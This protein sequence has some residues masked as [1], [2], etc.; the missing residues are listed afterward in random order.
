M[1]KSKVEQARELLA[2][3]GVAKEET[4]TQSSGV[5]RFPIF[6]QNEQPQKTKVQIAQEM[7]NNGMTPDQIRQNTE[8]GRVIPK[9]DGFFKTVAKEIVTPVARLGAN[10]ALAGRTAQGLVNP[11]AMQEAE[12]I[13]TNGINLPLV[14]QVKPVGVAGAGNGLGGFAR[15]VADA[16]GVGTE[17]ASTVIP[18]GKAP[19]IFGKF[20]TG[21]IATGIGTGA[22]VGGVGGGLFG[23]GRGV[24]EE[25]QRADGGF[26]LGN[27]ATDTA[28]G[29]AAGLVGGG[30][31]G[32]VGGVF[33]KVTAA[34]R[35]AR[36]PKPELQSELRSFVEG[37]RSLVNATE[38]MKRDRNT[39]VV[40]IIS[41]PT[42]FEGIK[43]V[44]GSLNVDA[45]IAT[46][47]STTD[48]LMDAN[49]SMLPRINEY[50]TPVKREDL[51]A[52]AYAKLR[53]TK[54][55]IANDKKKIDAELNAYDEYMSLLEVDELRA[56]S[57]ESA[58]IK[59]DDKNIFDA[60]ME[61][62][63]DTVFEKSEQV[64]NRISTDES[65]KV[66]GSLRTMIKDNL[67]A[68]E[69]LDKTLRGQK[70]PGGR[71]GAM[72]AQGVGAIIGSNGGPLTA[73]IG[74]KAGDAIARI[75]MN[76]RLGGSIRMG[77]IRKL[78]DD[79]AVLKAAQ[80]LIKQI[81]SY[82]PLSVPALPAPA[83]RLPA[84]Q[85]VSSV[86]VIPAE[87]G[88][89][90]RDIKTGKF[91]KTYLSGQK[92]GESLPKNQPSKTVSNF[93]PTQSNKITKIPAK[94]NSTNDSSKLIPTTKA[95]PASK[96]NTTQNLINEAKKYKSAE[97]I[98]NANEIHGARTQNVLKELGIKPDKDG[99]I[100]LYRGDNRSTMSDMTGGT[101]LTNSKDVAKGYGGKL[102]TVKVKPNQIIDAGDFNGGQSFNTIVPMK[103]DG[104]GRFEPI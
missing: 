36:D 80:E 33:G 45:A 3:G 18:S 52:A 83:I 9:Q 85:T 6:T 38:R 25:S 54:N 22:T 73:L 61:A 13:K 89:P 51:R 20:T 62:S 16:V 11:Q 77:L 63:R 81:D 86:S 91:F 97:L 104:T 44:D 15:D 19:S 79:P 76:N 59:A 2:S 90:G 42:V 1:P 12:R 29:A 58:K 47:R 34:R 95:P 49:R 35:F 70:V 74:A 28:E 7:L 37:K 40:D 64:A 67:N 55:Q 102:H 94:V 21:K 8:G 24:Q 96:V 98:K 82:N 72:F 93:L 53:G 100:T 17:I 30:V 31:L 50:T 71:L 41:D 43:P 60:I 23:L 5:K 39:D 10:F 27:I 92:N 84:K 78:N 57:R 32:G 14:G 69:F 4:T 46:L 101:Y 26:S 75:A 103:N 65:A 88:I 56:S 68:I 48:D 87:K 66:F 99:Y